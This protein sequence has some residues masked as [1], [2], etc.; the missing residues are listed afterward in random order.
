M[1][2]LKIIGYIVGT[3]V[4]LL[5]CPGI[6]IRL[7]SDHLSEKVWPPLLE[8]VRLEPARPHLAE[9][10]VGPDNAY[11]YIRQMPD[12][13]EEAFPDEIQDAYSQYMF[14]GEISAE[15]SPLLDRWSEENQAFVALLEA[16]AEADF[17]QVFTPDANDFTVPYISPVLSTGRLLSYIGEREARD[18]DWSSA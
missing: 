18:G 3:L 17:S 8:D 9:E 11:Y 16:V 12:F 2:A 10:D 15:R 4:V 14:E 6:G 13:W 7:Y 5:V 1:K